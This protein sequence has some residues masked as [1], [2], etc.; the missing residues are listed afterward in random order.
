MYTVDL[1]RILEEPNDRTRRILCRKAIS[2]VEMFDP[3]N[4]AFTFS[5]MGRSLPNAET[6]VRGALRFDPEC[7]Y[8]G[9]LR[10]PDDQ[11]DRTR[12]KVS[13]KRLAKFTY[14]VK[15][16]R[17]VEICLLRYL[18]VQR[19]LKQNKLVSQPNPIQD[20]VTPADQALPP[21]LTPQQ[22]VLEPFP[23]DLDLRADDEPPPGVRVD[24]PSEISLYIAGFIEELLREE[25]TAQPSGSDHQTRPS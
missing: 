14:S 7:R 12:N 9:F 3:G 11:T 23:L 22:G 19:K 1:V 15:W 18:Q 4:E 20:R 13:L 24:P 2:A 6:V 21:P 5:S 16:A 25:D 10:E 8:V 17:Y